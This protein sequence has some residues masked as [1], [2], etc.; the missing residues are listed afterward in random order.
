MGRPA[1]AF[2][3]LLTGIAL[4]A[5]QQ[6]PVFQSGVDLVAVD[7]RVFDR[8]G[9]PVAGLRPEE[10][11]VSFDG[12]PRTVTT[13][14]FVSYD[15][16]ST[17]GAPLSSRPQ[18]LFS[19]NLAATR[20]AAPRTIMLVVDEDNVRSG[21]AHW[22]AQAAQTLLDQA[23]ATDL[24]GLVTIPYGKGGIDP[25]TDR[26]PVRTALQSVVGHLTSAETTSLSPNHS[27]GLSEAFAY[28]HDQKGWRQILLRE[29]GPTAPAGCPQEMAGYAQTMMAD[30]RQR[31]T[32]T[33]RAFAGLLDGLAELP[34][35]KTVILISQELPVSGYSAERHDFFT[36]AAPVTA[37]AARAQATVYVVHL[38]A[39]LIDIETRRAPPSAWADADMRSYGLETITTMTGGRR[40]MI[41]GRPESAFERIAVE[42]SGYYLLGVR[43][44]AGDRDGKPHDIKVTVKR[45]GVEVR[46]RK[47]FAFSAPV[48][49]A[50]AKTASDLV[51]ALLQSSEPAT[52][53]TIAVATYALPSPPDTSP[54]DAASARAGVL[55]SAEVDRGRRAPAEFSVGYV[56]L[57]ATG[58]NAGLAVETVRLGPAVGH[59]DG[60]L[61][62]L[63]VALVPYGDYTLRLAV[64]DSSLR[65]GSVVHRLAAR[66][67]VG[68]GYALGDL[69][70]LDPYPSDAAEPRPSATV[71]A[72]GELAAYV[73]ARA[74]APASALAARLELAQTE[75][76]PALASSDMAI[77]VS[78]E[79]VLMNGAVLLPAGSGGTCVARVVAS[80]NGRV[81]GRVSRVVRIVEPARADPA[82]SPAAGAGSTPSRPSTVAEPRGT[83]PTPA[84]LQDAPAAARTAGGRAPASSI[85]EVVDRARV[86]LAD[87]AERLSLVIGIE[88]YAQYSGDQA[89]SRALGRQFVSEFAL[90][91]I[92][93][94]WLGFRDVYEIDGK[95][96]PD[97][98]DRLRKLFLESPDSALARARKISDE[99]AR[100]NLGAIQRNFNVPTMALFFLGPGNVGRF[101]FRKD[102]EDT[103]DGH[104]VW[105]IR[106][107][108][109]S[110]PTI[111]RTS[112]GKDM[113]V[114]GTFWID[115][116][117]GTV[118]KTHMEL[119]LEAK[120]GGT[121]R[122][123]PVM[124]VDSSAS[125]TVTYKQDPQLGLLVP[126][127]MLETYEGPSVNR[128]TGDEEVTKIN[129]SATYSEFRRFQ[130]SGRVIK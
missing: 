44:E 113:P 105:R 36:E 27:L 96:V 61:C 37:A 41:A 25:T 73:E 125:I 31:A 86:W 71:A 110:K 29:C 26:A 114:K 91:R 13:A 79:R 72:K 21:S 19:T 102:G 35:P 20:T 17:G 122:T 67:V 55:I 116:S 52:A 104:R 128:F 118:L 129:C 32:S 57:D 4:A 47:A 11:A 74:A 115:S 65:S 22:A 30:V 42:I 76:G 10:F 40:W 8:D 93:D 49:A 43:A 101:K 62:Y 63:A 28:R 12:K 77:Q 45:Q 119:S 124:R 107:E 59:P 109:T 81:V 1:L 80:L 92:K 23:Q 126:D 7:V 46:A 6:P 94:D 50:A 5:E 120:M 15:T 3:F 85:D 60:P 14:D 64:A 39:P 106:Y 103:I 18:P 88:R 78:G 98:E 108:E 121:V 70:V 123:S 89:F 112:L 58:R 83:E 66:P 34:G 99:S 68:A 2:V 53:V 16:T 75:D 95:P 111:I 24:I 38:D 90:V 48:G 100:H 51:R 130:T 82:P 127:R 9:R 56:L 54:G 117:D 97:R 87:Y 84:A 69:V 33:V